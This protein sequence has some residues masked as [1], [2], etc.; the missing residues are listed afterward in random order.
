MS[1]T[2]KNGIVE[3]WNG[4]FLKEIIYFKADR[5]DE[6]CHL[7]NVAVFQASIFQYSSIPEFQ[8]GGSQDL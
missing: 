7:P 1:T 2:W 4:G 3:G 5:Q 8:L 6:F